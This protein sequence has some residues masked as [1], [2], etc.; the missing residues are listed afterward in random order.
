M[1]DQPARTAA[2]DALTKNGLNRYEANILLNNFWFEVLTPV[3]QIVEDYVVESND[4][5]GL[6]CNDLADRL[7]TA[8]YELPGDEPYELPDD[9][10]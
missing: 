10:E 6:D 5:G 9:G 1:T 7:R 8:G 2:F 3:M 4:I